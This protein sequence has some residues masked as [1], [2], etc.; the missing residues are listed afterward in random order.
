LTKRINIDHLKDAELREL[1]EKKEHEIT[2]LKNEN[3]MFRHMIESMPGNIFWKDVNGIYLGCNHN[4]ASILG[5]AHCSDIIGK[6]NQ[7]LFEP[8]LAQSL[9]QNDELIIQSGHEISIEED[10]ID[11]NMQPAI[12][13]TKKQLLTNQDN[14]ITGILGVSFDITDR[15]KM[16]E[17]LR[18]AKEAAERASEDKSEFVTNM[19]HDIRTPLSGIIG[20][21]ELLTD[22]LQSAEDR[23]FAQSIM[24]S[25]NQ[26]LLF[27]NNCMEIF[28]QE[29]SKKT[30]KMM[31]VHINSIINNV[32]ELY[33]PSIQFKK[34]DL[35]VSYDPQ[36]PNVLIGDP[37]LLYRIL[38]NLVGNAIKFT[39]KGFIKIAILLET[40]STPQQAMIK[41]IIEDSGM[42][43]PKNK[44]GIIFDRFTRL[45]PTYKGIAEGSGIG[46][47]LVQQYINL[48][49]GQIHVVSQ[50]GKGSQFIV[51]LPFPISQEENSNTLQMEE[52]LA[53]QELPKT[54]PKQAKIKLKPHSTTSNQFV[55]ILLI[56]DSLI[57]QLMEYTLFT[58]L[59]HQVE[60]A[61]TGQEAINMFEPGKYDLIFLDIGLPDI[62]G[63]AVAQGIREKEKNTAQR[64]PIVALT[65]HMPDEFNADFAKTGID[66]IVNKPLSRDQAKQ[67]VIESV[68]I[69]HDDSKVNKAL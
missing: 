9:D 44:Q 67:L 38:L 29:L 59:G 23:E 30:L 15:K 10:A 57:V 16:E 50:L 68:E 4:L 18:I 55:K 62:L 33:K 31:P 58:S 3:I 12:Y 22:R 51:K 63:D 53:L 35:T 6:T 64:V 19:S 20:L 56:E 54:Q 43:I 24:N 52:L 26:L 66:K 34:L 8:L 37:I 46:L 17:D 60:L 61:N 27:F 42:G 14:E 47:Y 39:E 1:L 25:G 7:S 13:L 28:K 65:A 69:K 41:F 2:L 40:E 11:S 45:I 21:S 5:L 49:Q 32:V 48:M 36:L